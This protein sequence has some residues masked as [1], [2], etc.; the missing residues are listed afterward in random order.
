MVFIPIYLFLQG[1]FRL[2]FLINIVSLKLPVV[3]N[4]LEGCGETVKI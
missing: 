3:K 1:K 4:K 2:S